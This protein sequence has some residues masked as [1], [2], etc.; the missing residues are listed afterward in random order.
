LQYAYILD[1]EPDISSCA[2]V[3]IRVAISQFSHSSELLIYQSDQFEVFKLTEWT[4]IR[5]IYLVV[6]M[7]QAAE[8][9]EVVNEAQ[10]SG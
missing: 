7:L 1:A 2:G 3:D 6:L 10:I 9:C 5:L 4:G 8:F